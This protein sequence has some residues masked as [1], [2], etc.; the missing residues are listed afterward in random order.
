LV[1]DEDKIS[2]DLGVHGPVWVA[3]V[4]ED[5]ANHLSDFATE[6]CFLRCLQVVLT[7][8]VRKEGIDVG[9]EEARVGPA[10]DVQGGD[11][12]QEL[13]GRRGEFWEFAAKGGLV[14]LV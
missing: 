12:C 8:Q 3:Q 10:E 5:Q 14:P 1:G 4:G 6:G 9:E 13:F 2:T 11:H 7:L